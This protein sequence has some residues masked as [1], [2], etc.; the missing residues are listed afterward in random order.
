LQEAFRDRGMNGEWTPYEMWTAT[1][2]RRLSE[3]LKAECRARGLT[4]DPAATRILACGRAWGGCLAKYSAFMSRYLGLSQAAEMLPELSPFAGTPVECAFR[5]SLPLDR[6]VRLYLFQTPDGRPVGQFFDGLRGVAE[7]PHVAAVTID[8][9]RVDVLTVPANASQHPQPVSNPL[10]GGPL[11]V[12]VADGCRPVFTTLI[13]KGV[14]YDEFK[15]AL[16]RAR[17]E[18]L[19]PGHDSQMLFM[20]PASVP[21][22]GTAP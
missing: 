4:L 8:R 12:D 3:G 20:V 2:A 5:E 15:S 9:K 13:G 19:A 18:P 21:P 7:P 16:S 6:N 10:A 1:E 17:I 14:G 22:A 11:W